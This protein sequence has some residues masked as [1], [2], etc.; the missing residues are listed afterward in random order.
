M[1]DLLLAV[2]GKRKLSNW[3]WRWCSD[4][5]NYEVLK[6]GS[7]SMGECT[8]SISQFYKSC[9]QTPWP[10]SNWSLELCH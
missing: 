9:A 7:N 2:M 6:R 5:S 8:F 3:T 10:G 4:V 1:H